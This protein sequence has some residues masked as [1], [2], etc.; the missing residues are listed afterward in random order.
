MLEQ[1]R[2][3]WSVEDERAPKRDA[4]A[5]IANPNARRFFKL[6]RAALAAGDAK[7]AA[8]NLKL[9]LSVEPQSRPILEELARAEAL[10]EPPHK[11]GG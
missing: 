11:G 4:E 2:L 9:A 5:D 6:A 7:A 1:G 10:L 3:R 8:M